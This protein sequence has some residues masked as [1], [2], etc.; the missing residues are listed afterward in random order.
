MNGERK[1]R[2]ENFFLLVTLL[3]NLLLFYPW[4]NPI[5]DKCTLKPNNIANSPENYNTMNPT[6]KENL[7]SKFTVSNK[8]GHPV[9]KSFVIQKFLNSNFS[10]TIYC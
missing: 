9:Y 4:L 5:F 1:I 10:F 7:K 6:I 3:K 8:V 2:V